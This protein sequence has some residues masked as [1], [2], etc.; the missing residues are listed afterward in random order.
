LAEFALLTGEQRPRSGG[1]PPPRHRPLSTP[2]RIVEEEGD[3]GDDDDDG[4]GGIWGRTPQQ[5]NRVC[6][7]DIKPSR[8]P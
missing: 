4:D 8:S 3:D 1:P 2:P 6:Q 5:E 7:P